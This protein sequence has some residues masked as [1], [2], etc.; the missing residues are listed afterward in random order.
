[1]SG[2]KTPQQLLRRSQARQDSNLQPP[3]LEFGARRAV[4]YRL[5]RLQMVC[6]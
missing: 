5:V 6:N 2:M 1:M 3:V 4:L